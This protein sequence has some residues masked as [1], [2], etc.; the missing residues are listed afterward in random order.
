MKEEVQ[1]PVPETGT[2]FKSTDLN[3][4]AFLLTNKIPYRG[5]DHSED[6]RSIVFR[7]AQDERIPS[8]IDAYGSGAEVSARDFAASL[9][10][11]TGQIRQNRRKG[12]VQ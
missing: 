4:G 3:I 6:G 8:L 5:Y 9:R 10:F 12:G 1:N 11:L 7:F 2:L